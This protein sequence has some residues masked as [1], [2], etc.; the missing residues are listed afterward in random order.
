MASV[1]PSDWYRGVYNQSSSSANLNQ[2]WI[3]Q[4]QSMATPRSGKRRVMEVAA[5]G[6]PVASSSA[7]SRLSDAVRD[8][9]AVGKRTLAL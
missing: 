1:L 2:Y 9:C 7:L 4:I 3:D 5:D 8:T 6:M